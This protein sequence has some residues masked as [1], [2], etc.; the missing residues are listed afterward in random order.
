MGARQDCPGA[1]PAPLD[2]R[3]VWHRRWEYKAVGRGQVEK[4]SARGAEHDRLTEGLN[5]LAG[6]GWELLA[7]DPGH[8][9]GGG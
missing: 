5:Q 7:V 2:G 6:Q 8:P 3:H 1:V 9:V 4:L